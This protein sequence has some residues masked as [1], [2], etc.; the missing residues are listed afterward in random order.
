[1]EQE[2]P[3][4]IRVEIAVTEEPVLYEPGFSYADPSNILRID[5]VYHVWYVRWAW[6]GVEPCQGQG[7]MEANSVEWNTTMGTPNRIDICLAVSRDG[8]AWEDRG[9]VLPPSPRAAWHECARHAPHVVEVDG[10]YYLMF[11]SFYGDYSEEGLTG[12]KHF[13]VAVSDDPAGPFEHI[14]D[15]PVFSPSPEEGAFDHYLIDDPCVIRRNGELWM[16]YKGRPQAIGGQC[17]L[18]LARAEEMTGPWTRVQNTP[19]CELDWHTAC[20]WPHGSGLAGMVD[21]NCMAYSS[22]GLSFRAGA[23]L[24]REIC[25]SGVYRPAALSGGESSHGLPWGICL[26]LGAKIVGKL[27]RFELS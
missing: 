8:H 11:S 15:R 24:P 9:P 1:M 13:G 20:V 25:D 10:K 27:H 14:G 16:Y 4:A 21:W 19:V 26:I 22:D 2:V 3:E 7:V 12:E 18:G 5:G 23:K 17:W 6:Q